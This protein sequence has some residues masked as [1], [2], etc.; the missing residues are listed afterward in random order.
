MICLKYTHYKLVTEVKLIMLPDSLYIIE[1]GML[2]QKK[3]STYGYKK[4]DVSSKKHN[5][6]RGAINVKI[7]FYTYLF[8]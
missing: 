3:Q 5:K 2:Q 6:L 1:F 7:D 8:V 4:R